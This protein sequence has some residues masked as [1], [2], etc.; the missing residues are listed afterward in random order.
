MKRK[1]IPKDPG[2]RIKMPGYGDAGGFAVSSPDCLEARQIGPTTFSDMNAVRKTKREIWRTAL[3]L[4]Q[5]GC[6]DVLIVGT[7][8]YVRFIVTIK[9]P[10]PR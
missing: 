10:K 2:L 7:A 4:D 8:E 5:A 1:P 6:Q 9:F 3:A